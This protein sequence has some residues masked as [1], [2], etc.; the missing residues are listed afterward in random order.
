MTAVTQAPPVTAAPAP[1]GRRYGVRPWLLAPLLFLVL[2]AVAALAPALLSGVD[3]LA[4]DPLHALSGP[5]A[6]HWFGTDHLGRDVLS[7][8]VHGA[9]HS[10]AIGAAAILFAAGVGTVLGMLAG[11]SPRY[12]DELLSRLF[13]VLATFPELLLAL[14]VIAITG[15]GTGNVI[16]AIGMAQIPNYARVIRAQTFV[17]RRSG[18]VEQAVTFGLRRPVLV[19]RHVLPNV[20][21]P[22]PVL[23][24]IGMG[25]AIIATSGLSFLGMGPQPPSPEWGSMLSEARNYLRVAW[26]TALFP[27]LA[28][29]LTV[30]S[31]TLVGRRLQRRFEGR[32]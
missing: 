22:L 5:G 23:A 25:T 27:G 4:A 14:L 26:W 29:S 31:L 17:V 18:Y 8:V 7:R 30:I 21:G 16:L 3:P 20:L 10:L 6:G 11:L 32:Q 12:L 24:T 15:P 9:G 1:A 13:D 19:L 2:A 28:V